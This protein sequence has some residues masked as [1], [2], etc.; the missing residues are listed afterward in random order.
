MRDSPRLFIP[1]LDWIILA[2]T[3]GFSLTLLFFSDNLAVLSV[4]QE[5]GNVLTY[6]SRPLVV[7]RRAFDVFREN[8]ELR[9]LAMS[10]SQENNSLRDHASEN[11]RLRGMLQFRERFPFTLK[12]A[13]VIAYPG[14]EIGG[15]LVIDLGKDD[16]VRINSAAVM[17]AGLVGKVVELGQSSSVIQTLVGNSYGVSVMIERS[18]AM[19]ILR[20]EGPGSWT[21]VGLA[22]GEDVQLGDLV[23]TT[24]AGAVFPAHIRVG[25]ISD[26]RSQAEPGSGFCSVRPFVRFDS[27]EELFMVT[28]EAG[29]VDPA[30]EE[31]ESA[32]R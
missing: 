2:A 19:G 20:W 10:L 3:V 31:T 11:E 18:R 15:R 26:V 4:K 14:N 9:E 21:I 24:G 30:N 16:G 6:L 28:L 23:Q 8:A 5:A 7:V 25:I 1:Q 22:T 13:S 17:P 12:P 32:V 29:Q 27:I